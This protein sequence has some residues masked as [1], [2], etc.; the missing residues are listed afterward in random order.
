M[1]FL[2]LPRTL[3]LQNQAEDRA[4]RSSQRHL[5]IV[6]IS[7]VENSITLQLWQILRDELWIAENL[8]ES[9]AKNR[10]NTNLLFKIT[11]P[12]PWSRGTKLSMPDQYAYGL[13]TVH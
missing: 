11:L 9:G 4:Y 5:V 7:L 3:A 12:R 2:R 6:K 8:I 10:R 1:F 13:R